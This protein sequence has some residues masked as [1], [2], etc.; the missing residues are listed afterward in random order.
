MLVIFADRKNEERI[1]DYIIQVKEEPMDDSYEV[2][3]LGTELHDSRTSD[4]NQ[5]E[6][7]TISERNS[8]LDSN[9]DNVLFIAEHIK[10]E[11]D[12]K[13]KGG[14]SEEHDESISSRKRTRM[15]SSLLK[16]LNANPQHNGSTVTDENLVKTRKRPQP[17][18][19]GL[20][21][22]TVPPTPLN[23][24]IT[25][26][27]DNDVHIT[28][29]T[30]PLSA[31]SGNS[32][33]LQ[34][35]LASPYSGKSPLL[36]SM[37]KTPSRTES[38]IDKV[39]STPTV[40]SNQVNLMPSIQGHRNRSNSTPESSTKLK[41]PVL[42]NMGSDVPSKK[43]SNDRQ[44]LSTINELVTKCK[45]ANVTKINPLID[46]SSFPDPHSGKIVP[47]DSTPVKCNLQNNGGVQTDDFINR[48]TEVITQK[49]ISEFSK[50]VNA[51]LNSF[52]KKAI[53]DSI[54]DS[55]TNPVPIVPTTTAAS[56]TENQ[57]PNEVN[58]VS[59]LAS[60]LLQTLAEKVNGC[61]IQDIAKGL[62]V[63]DDINLIN[64]CQNIQKSSQDIAKLLAS[65]VTNESDQS[66]TV[67]VQEQVPTSSKPT[68][69]KFE[70]ENTL[71]CSTNNS[72]PTVPPEEVKKL[73]SNLIG[74]TN[75][76]NVNQA[77]SERQVQKPPVEYITIPS[78]NGAEE[79]KP[80]ETSSGKSQPVPVSPIIT[81]I[82]HMQ[83]KDGKFLIFSCKICG[84]RFQHHGTLSV[85][86]R[87]H[88]M[89]SGNSEFKCDIC[90][91]LCTAKRY[92]DIHMRTHQKGGS[93]PVSK[94]VCETCQG[95][96]TSEENL[97]IH[98]RMHL[99][100]KLYQ[101]DVCQTGFTRKSQ[102]SI[103][104]RIHSGEKPYSCSI[105][106][107]TFRQSNGLSLHLN[108]HTDD[109]PYKCEICGSGFSRKA[110]YEKH[111]RKERGERPFKCE[112]CG[113]GFTDKFNLRMHT[114]THLKSKPHQCDE[115]GKSFVQVAY[116]RN[117]KKFHS[118]EK[119]FDCP[120]C[121][122]RFEIRK[123]FK[124]HLTTLHK[125]KEDTVTRSRRTSAKSLK[126]TYKDIMDEDDEEEITSEGESK[127]NSDEEMDKADAYSD[128]IM[129]IATDID[130]S[131]ESRQFG[132]EETDNS[133]DMLEFVNASQDY[134]DN[135]TDSD[136]KTEP[137]GFNELK[138]KLGDNKYINFD[139]SIVKRE[140]EE[141][142]DES[143]LVE[144]HVVKSKVNVEFDTSVIKCEPFNS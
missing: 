80:V 79:P 113:K 131:P 12:D 7:N 117:H 103:H 69:Q 2:I 27:I 108:V 124:D 39:F 119:G 88:I 19:Y 85:H 93:C 130:G 126:G 24:V 138:S 94:L 56:S 110:H 14:N 33:T 64:V 140:P 16:I 86:M 91:K 68:V 78:E 129:H 17:T 122:E 21:N 34:K 60:C 76:S 29:I 73:V 128:M 111:M 47:T 43:K 136:I 46:K 116:L 118:G 50:D 99:G 132:T 66:N 100:E 63:E 67:N 142:I 54:K 59:S 81:N 48:W 18:L 84:K 55:S 30:A 95:E 28:H 89:E 38:T 109:K 20:L 62:N 8:A 141:I 61:G 52:V 137:I 135:F 40:N 65:S 96:F 105:C 6:Q 97:L 32:T 22:G 58:Q 15:S 35:M 51:T 26:T 134:V 13:S 75:K 74:K 101:C 83:D 115:C 4:F 45:E 120:H 49:V 23:S 9:G 106:G 25:D 77:K 57:V 123:D 107:K 53:I 112:E 139:P 102:L 37:L 133:T 90:G 1:M 41:L 104:M 143:A 72:V 42:L 121:P 36:S 125:D 127:D 31:K 98:K 11:P 144:H 114:R 87:T 82:K 70:I 10:S 44:N 5:I 71:P 3:H 92:L